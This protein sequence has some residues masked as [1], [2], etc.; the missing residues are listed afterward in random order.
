[1]SIRTWKEEF[2]PKRSCDTDEH[3]AIDHSIRKWI[4]LRP[5]NLAKHKVV[6]DGD[7]GC[8]RDAPG[9]M[10]FVD[11]STCALCH[12]FRGMEQ[13]EWGESC[14]G[15]PLFEVRDRAQC[16]SARMNEDDAPYFQFMHGRDPEPMI[17]DLLRAKRAIDEG[18]L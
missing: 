17:V 8:L 10:A 9:D 2:Y 11:S 5:E 16:D 3:E 18:A 6:W 4:G 14:S 13:D 15:C 1:M 7:Y 12:H